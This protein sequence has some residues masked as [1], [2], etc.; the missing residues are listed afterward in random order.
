MQLPGGFIKNVKSPGEPRIQ[1]VG[2]YN[3]VDVVACI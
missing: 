2:K 1:N 3:F